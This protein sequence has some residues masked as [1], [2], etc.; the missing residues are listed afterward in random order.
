MLL[1]YPIWAF[2]YKLFGARHPFSPNHPFS[3]FPRF[4]EKSACLVPGTL[5]PFFEK[6]ILFFFKD[7]V[8]NSIVKCQFWLAFY[9]ALEGGKS[10]M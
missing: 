1:L 6:N 8:I 2:F 7:C 9:A 3:P 5:A 10:T 4:P